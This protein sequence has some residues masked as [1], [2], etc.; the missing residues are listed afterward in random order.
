MMV[1]LVV[2]VKVA[3]VA[4][5]RVVHWL[6]GVQICCPKITKAYARPSQ[7]NLLLVPPPAGDILGGQVQWQDEQRVGVWVASSLS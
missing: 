2:V 3:V 5:V 1:V 7:S 6:R 4:A